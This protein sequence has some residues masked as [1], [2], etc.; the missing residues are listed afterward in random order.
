MRLNLNISTIID[1]SFQI[2]K[3]ILLVLDIGDQSWIFIWSLT[4]GGSSETTAVMALPRNRGG[5]LS[6]VRISLARQQCCQI[7]EV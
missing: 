3:F 7:L 4:R 5:E 6:E 1:E 2:R